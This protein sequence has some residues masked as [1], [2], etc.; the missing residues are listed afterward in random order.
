MRQCFFVIIP[1]HAPPPP[2]PAPGVFEPPEPPRPLPLDAAEL[3]NYSL[4]NN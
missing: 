3:Q 2:R 4:I 1:C